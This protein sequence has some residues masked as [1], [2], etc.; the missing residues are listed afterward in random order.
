MP[1]RMVR[2]RVGDVLLVGYSVAGVESVV[3]VPEL[4]VCFDIGRAPTEVVCIDTICLTHGHMD[5]AAGIA[6]Y[7]S[8]RGFIGNSPGRI[9]VPRPLAQP[10]QA[11]MSVWRDIE[12]H[13][14]SGE[15]VAVEAGQ[16]VSIRRDLVVRAFAV[17]H[18]AGALGYS[19]I[20]VR[21]KLKPEYHDL[22]GP[23]IVELKEK[24]LPVQNRVEVPLVAYCGDTAVGGFLDEDCVRNAG[25]LLL[26]CTFFEGEHI[27]RARAGRHIHVCDLQEVMKRVRCPHVALM[28]LSQRTDLR[29]AR[30]TLADALDEA[31][32]DRISFL[33]ERPPR[34]RGPRS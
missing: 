1:G 10:V 30:K 6:Y 7:F 16:D 34:D 29:A 2:K 26:E 32:L 24:G 15:V 25:V 22:S 5:H 19:V 4:N 31:D 18:G 17:N 28:H 23:Q 21:H 12:G 14:S 27:T 9:L 11:L 3:A 13:Y 33:M 8:Q 20:E